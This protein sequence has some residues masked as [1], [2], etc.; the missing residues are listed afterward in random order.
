MSLLH[1]LIMHAQEQEDRNLNFHLDVP[2][3]SSPLTRPRAGVY[4]RQVQIPTCTP[5]RRI[6]SAALTADSL[7][8]RTIPRLER[9][10]ADHKRGMIAPRDGSYTANNPILQAL[11]ALS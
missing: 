1:I 2:S 6:H 9:K 11:R 5:A 8:C 7:K 10:T 3:E 4:I